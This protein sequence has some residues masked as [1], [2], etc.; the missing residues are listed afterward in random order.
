MFLN[1]QNL[2]DSL[3]E[4]GFV[5]L[6]DKP[7]GFTSF[8]VVAGVRKALSTRFQ[9]K[10]KIGHAGTL[11]PL[12]SGLLI[13]CTGKMTKQIQQYQGA[14]KIY[15]G[16]FV[17]GA[18][19][20]S[21]DMETE[22]DQNFS[23]SELK[24]EALF[25]TR[26]SFMGLQMISPPVHSAIK[27]DGKRAYHYARKDQISD[28]PPRPMHIHD[29]DI[30]CNTFP[31]IRFRIHCTKGTYIR[32]IA[33]EFGKRLE[34]GAYLSSLVRTQIGNFKLTNAWTYNQLIDR[35]RQS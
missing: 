30:D 31:E 1:E 12:A 15:E 9:S 7:L 8:Q 10:I 3:P 23:I 18:S 26:D 27:I 19:R 32:S 21:Y 16:S 14:D 24:T 29:F 13:L 6:I 34:N 33:H 2:P 28:L 22:I 11:D 35:L 25:R 17:L 5:I 4:E 20:P